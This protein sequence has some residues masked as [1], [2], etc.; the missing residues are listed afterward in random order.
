MPV[1]PEAPQNP[2]P[3]LRPFEPDEDHLFFGRE[4]QTDDLLRKLRT[5]RFV[6]VT[7]SSG[8]GK[9][10]LVRSGL[11]PSLDSGLMS[12]AGSSWR[13]AILR[14]GEDPIGNLAAA[15][16]PPSV[17]GVASR[18]GSPPGRLLFDITLRRGSLGIIEAVRQARIPAQDNV[19][20]LVDQFEELFRF[21]KSKENPD[22]HNDA[23]AFVK[24][25]LEA[26]T[27]DK[28]PIF[29]VLTMR[30]DFIGECM[31]FQGL[32]EA[33]NNGQYLVPRMTRDQL[34]SAI[35]GPVAVAG[36]SIAPRL[37]SRLLNDCG[38][39]PD[40]LPV[41]QHALMRTWDY[42]ARHRQPG[43]PLDISDY[44]AIGTL[45]NA[46]SIHAEEAFSEAAPAG[47]LIAERIFKSLVDTSVQGKWVRRPTAI[48]Q[49]A[50]I[51]DATEA[52]VIAIADLFRKPG[53]SFLTPSAEAP[54]VSASILDL[55]HE[56]LM[57]CWTRLLKWTE[58][59]KASSEQYV[60]LAH[61]AGCY[62]E[63]KVGLWTAP[64]LD[65]AERWYNTN[66][67]NA[68]WAERLNPDWPRAIAFLNASA[69]ERDRA[70]AERAATR[71][72]RL[73]WAWSV[74]ATLALLLA[75]TASVAA[76]AWRENKR[77]RQNLQLAKDSLDSVLSAASSGFSSMAV[78]SPEVENY[79]RQII[80]SA[81]QISEK[82]HAANAGSEF[83]AEMALVDLRLGDGERVRGQAR[84]A[85]EKYQ[86][87][88]AHLLPLSASSPRDNDIQSRLADAYNWLGEVQRTL[89]ALRTAA[90]TSYDRA[91]KLQL[92]LTGRFPGR[93]DYVLAAARTYY[94]R[95][96]A[97]KE[98]TRYQD[99]QTGFLD[100]IRL[101]TPLADSQKTP[102]YRQELARAKN[103]LAQ[104]SWIA[105]LP[106]D[107]MPLQSD[108]IAGA[109]SLVSANPANR[110]YQYELAQYL[111]NAAIML[112][113]H[114]ELERAHSDN[115]EAIALY[116]R[117]A[118][119]LAPLKMHLGLAYQIRGRILDS[120]RSRSAAAEYQ[121][122]LDLF[123]EVP[124]ESRNSD[125]YT[126]YGNALFNM[127][128]FMQQRGHHPQAAALLLR[129]AEQH[130]AIGSNNYRAWDYCALIDSYR[131][132]KSR[133]ALQ[134]AMDD[135]RGIIPKVPEANRP[136]LLTC[137]TP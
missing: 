68:A 135:L 116:N 56:S 41:L 43:G 38:D 19:L 93:S 96:I 59:E 64:E 32:P 78:N 35:T 14:P 51:C 2:F 13:T 26:A 121:R 91:L 90:E 39:D 92:A 99:A 10:S 65:F 113:S 21:R 119:P 127:A 28:L 74:A 107:P 58:E 134:R 102:A 82:I 40:Q 20:I 55:S 7:G 122:S 112:E 23:A 49:L 124:A 48:R 84:A 80:Q 25:L 128:R 24:L 8:S 60:Q 62:D 37:V 106:G 53:R 1:P 101:L 125:F 131:A 104:L 88:V 63:G 54:L 87:A 67:P 72:R 77:A 61:D 120:G 86:A 114:G 105:G 89:P 11:V 94:N 4:R 18:E 126:W 16:E 30:A 76:V 129:A 42:W 85:I 117:L 9:S 17:L 50:Q 110:D 115:E 27:Q 3:G 44:E 57:R 71:R 36:G 111:D 47:Q 31:A 79:H 136:E 103:N 108:A 33:I 70:A 34:R 22:S 133:A 73:L 100:A 83:T 6:L 45:Q 95:S 52:E 97:Y 123:E 66:R 81:G 109:R 15:L 5:N 98:D 130:T 75:L 132:M 12:Q 29:V 46:L 69:L 137:L 118:E